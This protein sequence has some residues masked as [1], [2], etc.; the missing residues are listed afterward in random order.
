MCKGLEIYIPSAP[1]AAGFYFI[2]STGSFT[3]RHA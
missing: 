2:G 1:L 3:G